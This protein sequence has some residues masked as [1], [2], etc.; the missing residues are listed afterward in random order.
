MADDDKT[1]FSVENLVKRWGLSRWTI[2]RRADEGFIRTV[3]FGSRRLVPADEVAR[4]D[5]DGLPK[6]LPRIMKKGKAAPGVP[7]ASAEVLDARG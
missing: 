3:Y 1:F 4:I 6:P 7:P 5:R 2:S